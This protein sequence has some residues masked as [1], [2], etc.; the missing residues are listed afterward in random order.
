MDEKRIELDK[1]EDETRMKLDK[2]EDEKRM[3]LDK[4]KITM[5]RGERMRIEE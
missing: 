3:K 4:N 1:N 5:M 2:N